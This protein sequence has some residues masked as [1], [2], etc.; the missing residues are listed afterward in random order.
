MIVKHPEY[1]R[2]IVNISKDKSSSVEWDSGRRNYG[3]SL[4]SPL[5]ME[6]KILKTTKR[7]KL[8]LGIK[9]ERGE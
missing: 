5:F 1:G 8:I 6:C 7:E 2:G 9:E 4:T 3:V